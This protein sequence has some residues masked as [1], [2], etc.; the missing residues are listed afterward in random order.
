[1]PRKTDVLIVGSGSA[2][3]CAAAWLAV[4]G[5]PCTILESR[6]GPLSVGQADGVQCR[7]LEIFDSFNLSEELLREAYHVLEV[8]FWGAGEG[9]S[10]GIVRTG[11]T[12]DREEGVSWM[13]HVILNQARINGLLL[14]VMARGGQGVEYGWGVKGVEVDRGV[15]GDHGAY[16]ARVVA[17]REGV[18]EVFEAKYVLGCDGAH[19]VV[20]RALDFRMVG[21]S[22]DSVW[23]VMDIFPITDF[24]DIRKKAALQSAHGSLLIIPREGGMMVRFYIELPHG[25]NTKDVRIED[26]QASAKKIFQPYSLEVAETRWWSAYSIGQRVADHFT[27]DDRAFLTGDACHTHSPKAGQGMNVSLQDG[28]NIG[29]K[30]AAVLN[31]RA[32]P[33]L[34]KTYTLERV[35]VAEDLI[36]FD[37]EIAKAF[38]AKK[39]SADPDAANRYAKLFIE[40]GKYTA[41]VMAKY[42]DSDITWAAR[43][44]QRLAKNVVVGMRFPSAQVV[45]MSDAKAMQLAK[46]LPSDGRWRIVV[47]AGDLSR[48]SAAGDRLAR[49]SLMQ[50]CASVFAADAVSSLVSILTWTMGQFVRLRLPTRILTV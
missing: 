1:M 14:E 34:L 33:E 4:H 17:E 36:A 21:D 19:S 16:C 45:R 8:V 18:E 27:L 15:T 5:V 35:K 50:I 40:T 2:G 44:T 26:L 12:A 25:M 31:G 42:D 11:R 3:L 9:A 7:T 37:R 49:V 47:F 23:G 20:R 6:P 13:P 24:P 48:D 43:S 38:A 10:G 39:S 46:A 29:W 28:F 22:T 32:R 41:G 30:L